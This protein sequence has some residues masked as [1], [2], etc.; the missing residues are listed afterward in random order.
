MKKNLTSLSTILVL[1]T[2]FF[3]SCKKDD[4]TT[5]PKNKTEL[6]TQ[7]NWKFKSAF[8]GTT[9]YSSG[10]QACQKDNILTFSANGSGNADEGVAKCNMADPQSN[11][12][13]WNFQTSETSI[14]ISTILF[15]G[16]SKNFDLISLTE[17]ELVVSQQFTPPVGPTQIVVVTFIH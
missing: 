15:T 8:V 14:F 12:F 6:I 10:L 16:G 13:T 11:P 9:D 2:F 3:A 5:T 17:T 7:S 4:T 1:I